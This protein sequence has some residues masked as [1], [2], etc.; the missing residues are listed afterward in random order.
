MGYLVSDTI[1]KSYTCG[2]EPQNG[3]DARFYKIEDNHRKAT[4][5]SSTNQAAGAKPFNTLLGSDL[6]LQGLDVRFGV[7]VELAALP[8]PHFHSK[9]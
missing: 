2:T 6:R 8:C 4:M 3:L 9:T 7:G 5:V 1:C